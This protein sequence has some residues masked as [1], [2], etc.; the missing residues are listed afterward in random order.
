MYKKPR[1]DIYD[2]ILNI[3]NVAIV[4]IV[5]AAFIRIAFQRN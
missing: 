3:I 2:L 5:H 4:V 1:M